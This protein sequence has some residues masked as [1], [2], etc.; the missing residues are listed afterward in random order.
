MFAVILTIALVLSIQFS[1]RI[2][3]EGDLRVI[4]VAVEQEIQLLQR[5]QAQLKAQLDYVDSGAYVEEWAR[6]EARMIRPGEQLYIPKPEA[7]IVAAI[8][9]QRLEATLIGD[10]ETTLP[11][12]ANW[13]IWWQLFFDWDLPVRD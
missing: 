13:H 4:Q 11:E 3:V 2:A 10:V 8:E 12:P 5:E 1:T 6:S 9:G 7:R